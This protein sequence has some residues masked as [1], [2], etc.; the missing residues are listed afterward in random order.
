MVSP[1]IYVQNIPN[2]EAFGKGKE[3]QVTGFKT[4]THD[5][6]SFRAVLN[7]WILAQG[8]DGAG[9]V[10]GFQNPSIFNST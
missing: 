7:C 4:K 6:W 10:G 9:G 2:S 5:Y 1:T 8:V 3:L